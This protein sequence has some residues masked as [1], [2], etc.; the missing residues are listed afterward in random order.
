MLFL[1]AQPY[2]VFFHWDLCCQ[3]LNI[4][5]SLVLL[6]LW[7][8]LLSN[9]S[10]RNL[11]AVLLGLFLPATPH[12][13]DCSL[14]PLLTSV[15]LK[16]GCILEANTLNTVIEFSTT[17]CT[18]ELIWNYWFSVIDCYQSVQVPFLEAEYGTQIGHWF[19]MTELSEERAQGDW[20]RKGEELTRGKL[21]SGCWNKFDSM[22]LLL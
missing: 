3:L 21:S 18:S 8:S 9:L 4:F 20:T 12:T 7:F 22:C 2:V 5:T 16:V 14:L 6:N 13:S 11:R 17:Q 1:K 15:L 10:S 19:M